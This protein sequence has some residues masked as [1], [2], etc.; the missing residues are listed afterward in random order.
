MKRRAAKLGLTL[1]IAVSPALA[2][3]D[4]APL[5]DSRQ[6]QAFLSYLMGGGKQGSLL[7]G[8][9]DL[10]QGELNPITFVTGR[11]CI[12]PNHGES[13]HSVTYNILL[14]ASRRRVL[15]EFTLSPA[16]QQDMV[17]VNLAELARNRSVTQ[18]WVWMASADPQGDGAVIDYSS[19]S[20]A[21][22]CA[23]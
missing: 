8:L 11:P 14:G 3:L 1:C 23:F 13:L 19:R 22:M 5:I 17:G 6:E 10:E 2:Q 7:N 15:F 18:Y 20:G 9:P 4:E 12:I 16:V 21:H